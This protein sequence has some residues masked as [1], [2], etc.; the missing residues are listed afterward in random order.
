MNQKF[1]PA[2]IVIVALAMPVLMPTGAEAIPA[3]SK[4]YEAPCSMCHAS[5]PRLNDVGVKF[6]LNGYQMP[7]TEDGGERA[8]L[9]PASN[10]FLD[11]GS[12]NPPISLRLEGGLI[13][14]QPGQGPDTSQQDKFFCCVE[15][16]AVTVDAGGSLAPNIGFWLSLPWG[17]ESVEQ[18][19]LRFVNWFSPGLL[20][21]DIGA[22]K[23]V[24]YDVVGAGREWFGSPL[25]AFYGNPYNNNSKEIGLTATHHDTGVRFY[26]R[27]SYDVFTYE[28]GIYTGS[29]I[30]SSGED[31]SDLAYTIMGRVDK[32]K[33]SASLRYWGNSSGMIDQ[34]VTDSSGNSLIFPADPNNADEK[35]QEFILS[36]RYTHPYFVVDLTLD[37]TSLTLGER[38]ITTDESSHT[39]NQETINRTAFSLGAIWYVNSWFETGLAYGFSRYNDYK[40][41]IDDE[42]FEIGSKD[43]GLIQLRTAFRPTMNMTIGLEFQMD[44]SS[45]NAR[46]RADGTSFDA[47]NKLVLQWDLAL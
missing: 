21:M 25:L 19:Y 32:G 4:K 15:G 1:L 47:Q 2:F 29:H 14:M 24:D 11:I 45:S 34:Q 27:P 26:G 36:A 5:W 33:I 41:T 3:F 37:R 44:T 18:G 28:L 22:M 17:K 16:N 43:V 20:G 35:T 6:K 13:L 10:L 40:Q 23:V 8:K 31:D 46:K 12:A 38:S 30:T 39:F 42:I 7:D 9:S